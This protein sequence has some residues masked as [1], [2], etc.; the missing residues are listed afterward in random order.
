M[1]PSFTCLTYLDTTCMEVIP[2]SHRR[3][4]MKLWE[5]V[6]QFGSRVRLSLRVSDVLLFHS[7]LLHRGIFTERL[8]H[9]RLI[10]VFEV[11][12]SKALYECY[13]TQVVHIPSSMSSEKASSV[14]EWVYES[15][16]MVATWFGYLNAATGYGYSSSDSSANSDETS[17]RTTRALLYS[18]EGTRPR[19]IPRHRSQIKVANSPSPLDIGPIWQPG[20]HYILNSNENQVLT[21]EE[22]P[23]KKDLGWKQYNQQFLTYGVVIGF[24][25]LGTLFLIF[26]FCQA[27]TKGKQE[28]NK[29]INLKQP[30]DP[31]WMLQRRK[32][33][34]DYRD[35]RDREWSDGEDGVDGWDGWDGWVT[36]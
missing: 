29:S 25:V 7:C 2:G 31:S 13:G 20:N 30:C 12:P 28:G 15:T 10:Q 9:R 4:H 32:N 1:E 35:Q 33:H 24:F 23:T 34:Y 18:S 16:A 14:L 17:Q 5:A 26:S 8:P 27:L 11:F 3:P 19:L 22:G 6:S 21:L 36:R